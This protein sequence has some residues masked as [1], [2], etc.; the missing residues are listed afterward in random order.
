MEFDDLKSSWRDLDARFSRADARIDRLAASIAAGKVASSLE[1]LRRRT[2]LFLL[3]LASLPFGFASLFRRFPESPSTALY[4]ALGLFVCA[5]LARQLVLLVLLGR[6]RPE[7]QSVRDLC[8][9]VLRLRRCFLWGVAAGLVL[10]VPLVVSFGC[11]LAPMAD[12]RPLLWGFA[13]GLIAG[14][15]IGL[16]VFLRMLREIDSLQTAVEED[17][18]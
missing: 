1:W 4:V 18:A 10:A 14:C 8:C 7:R 17:E 3:L 13:G 2:F 5:M 11:W 6:I 16:R 12:A 15:A 9:A